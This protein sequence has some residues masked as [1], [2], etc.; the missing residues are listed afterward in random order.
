MWVNPATGDRIGASSAKDIEFNTW[1]CILGFPVIGIWPGV[2][3]TDVNSTCRSNSRNTLATADDFGKVKLFK[4][5]C[6]VE[7]AAYKEYM[8]HSSHVTKV[9]FSV[10]D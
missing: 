10:N 1:T 5:P 9:K 8:G 4:Y 2:D 3:Y 7:K 6:C